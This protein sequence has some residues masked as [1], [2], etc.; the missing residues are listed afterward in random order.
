M[1]FWHSDLAR[2]C[3]AE[4]GIPGVLMHEKEVEGHEVLHVQIKTAAAAAAVGKPCGRYVTVAPKERDRTL[5]CNSAVTARILGV[6]LRDMA[7]RMTG[8]RIT[9]AFS[10]LAVG[11]GNAE[12]TPDA[13]GP[14]T[15]RRLT[16]TR[17]RAR[18]P[19][20][21]TGALCRIAAFAPG[22]TA[23]TGLKTSELLRGA[24]AAVQP[25]LLLAVDAL[26]ARETAHLHATVQLSD[27]GI[28][29]GSGVGRLG[30]ALSLETLGVPVLSLGVPTVVG[31]D[32]LVGDALLRCGIPRDAAAVAEWME[33]GRGFFVTPTEIDL[34]VPLFADLLAEAVG[35]A[36]CVT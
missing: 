32:T 34:L 8:K 33:G 23:A 5:F 21:F 17:N 14:A 30:E 36:F 4:P 11:L 26:A 9:P 27:T 10:L 13:L 35:R 12:I 15:V 2:E 6:E 31:S 18:A 22:V 28:L 19:Q 1:D 24:I 3:C 7:E 20:P 29:P 16:I 25:D